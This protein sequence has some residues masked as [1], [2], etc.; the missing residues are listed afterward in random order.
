MTCTRSHWK[1]LNRERK[2]KHKN[3]QKHQY[4]SRWMY[5]ER[6]R[7]ATKKIRLYTT[8]GARK[9]ERL[10]N[11]Q[12]CHSNKYDWP[13]IQQQ[14]T[15]G[16]DCGQEPSSKISSTLL[17]GF[18]WPGSLGSLWINASC[19]G[20]VWSRSTLTTC[21]VFGKGHTFHAWMRNIYR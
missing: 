11:K 17:Q 13:A 2:T 21:V 7:R 3:R 15:A 20:T 14:Y 12:S 19:W 1:K 9:W 5:R 6:S 16:R 10:K 8:H 18:L 4:L